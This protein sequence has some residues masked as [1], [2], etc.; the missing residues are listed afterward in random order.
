MLLFQNKLSQNK[1]KTLVFLTVASLLLVQA[2]GFSPVYKKQKNPNGDVDISTSLQSVKVSKIGRGIKGQ[3]LQAKLE[4]LFNPT[5][6]E[7]TKEY[8]LSIKLNQ[9]KEAQLVRKIRD[10]DRYNIVL[11]GKFTLK[12]KATNK[13]VYKGKSK[14]I[15]GYGVVD[16]DFATLSAE[17]DTIKRVIDEMAKDINFKIADYFISESN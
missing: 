12:D 15:S 1:G 5:R 7:N 10:I 8:I 3:Q 2:C 6:I 13:E 9:K 11:T 14:I 17:E 16:S 4:D